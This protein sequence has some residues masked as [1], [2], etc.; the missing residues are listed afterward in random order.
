MANVSAKIIIDHP[1][2]VGDE[3]AQWLWLSQHRENGKD[4]QE[5][6][7]E[8]S[9]HDGGDEQVEVENARADEVAIWRRVPGCHFGW[10]AK[11]LEDGYLDCFK[12]VLVLCFFAYAILECIHQQ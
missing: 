5:N 11:L 2:E 10:W 7:R 6:Q 9:G 12:V 1:D 4:D 8:A 3:R